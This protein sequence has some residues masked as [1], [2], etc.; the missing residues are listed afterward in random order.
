MQPISIPTGILA[1][2]FAASGPEWRATRT[3]GVTWRAL[4]LADEAA[5]GDATVLIRMEPGCSYP[6][7]EHRGVEEVLILAG[8]YRDA[9]GEHGPGT[10][11]RYPA[12]SRHLPIALGDPR[13]P[14][15]SDN[16]ACLLFAIARDGV[17]RKDPSR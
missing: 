14:V 9:F 3:P 15:S 1:K 10:Y 4:H 17:E 12:R 8:G 2:E 5:G 6:E 16:P 13:R 7:H 11:L